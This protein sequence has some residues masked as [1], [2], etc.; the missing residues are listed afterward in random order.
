[1]LEPFTNQEVE[2]GPQYRVCKAQDC[3]CVYFAD[4]IN[5][6]F[7]LDDVRVRVN[8]KLDDDERPFFLCYCFGYGKEGVISEIENTAS[9]SIVDWIKDRVQAEEYACRWKPCRRMLSR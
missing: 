9:S 1:M 7:H 6:H 5:Q 3:D 4:E 2:D 8:F